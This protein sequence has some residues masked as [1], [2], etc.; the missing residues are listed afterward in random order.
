MIKINVK[1]IYTLCFYGNDYILG[2]GLLGKQDLKGK[3][4]LI[5]EA[6]YNTQF[7]WDY[8][9]YFKMHCKPFYIQSGVVSCKQSLK[10]LYPLIKYK[11][12][13][14]SFIC[15]LPACCLWILLPL[16]CYEQILCKQTKVSTGSD[17]FTWYF[18]LWPKH[19]IDIFERL[20][21]ANYS[22]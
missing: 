17:H 14:I 22:Y 3:L 20:F 19:F 2:W 9:S 12:I 10:I 1:I 4:A 13:N 5:L 15:C 7:Y 21:T 8:L 18:Q 6:D 16:Y 11:S